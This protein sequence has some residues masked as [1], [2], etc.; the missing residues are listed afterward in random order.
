MPM[1]YPR[2]ITITPKDSNTT[3]PSTQIDDTQINPDDIELWKNI[4]E[5]TKT[6]D[7]IE[8]K[9]RKKKH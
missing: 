4:K 5:A 7:L 8:S 3:F 9:E 1:K 2:N 6:I